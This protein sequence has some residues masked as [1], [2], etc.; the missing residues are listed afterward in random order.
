MA[1]PRSPFPL[2]CGD[3]EKANALGLPP[4]GS[5]RSH[6]SLPRG[7]TPVSCPLAVLSSLAQHS[8]PAGSRPAAH[9]VRRRQP[10][11]HTALISLKPWITGGPPKPLSGRAEA[12]GCVSAPWCHTPPR[13]VSIALPTHFTRRL[14]PGGSCVEEAPGC[15]FVP[16]Y[17]QRQ[18]RVASTLYPQAAAKRLIALSLL[19]SHFS[20]L[21][22]HFSLLTSARPPPPSPVHLPCSPLSRSTLYPRAP[23]LR[24]MRVLTSP[25][26]RSVPPRGSSRVPSVFQPGGRHM[27]CGAVSR[28]TTPR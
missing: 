12:P 3:G 4:G 7:P 26:S 2:F 23:A 16:W 28:R 20:L 8:L 5:S 17:A 19:T 1:I 14:P 10:P 21:T 11:H 22:S 9:A 18:H 27:R 13:G 24:L 6:F 25:L 15:V